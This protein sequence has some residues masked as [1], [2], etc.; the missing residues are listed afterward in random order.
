MEIQLWHVPVLVMAGII[1]VYYA[2]VKWFPAI[3]ITQLKRASPWFLMVLTAGL[4]S[5][6]WLQFGQST[7]DGLVAIVSTCMS[8][9]SFWLGLQQHRERRTQKPEQK[10]DTE[11]DG[12]DSG[13]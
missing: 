12:A 3:R 5:L 11:S 10:P 4:A 9:G 13:H 7:V 1:A 6:A 8:V 2:V